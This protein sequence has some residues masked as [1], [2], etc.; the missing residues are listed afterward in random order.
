MKNDLHTL[1]QSLTYKFCLTNFRYVYFKLLLIS[2]VIVIHDH[3]IITHL[4]FVHKSHQTI[5]RYSYKLIYQI[6]Y[7]GEEKWRLVYYSYFQDVLLYC[8]SG[9]CNHCHT[10]MLYLC[11]LHSSLII[12]I[13]WI[14]LKRI[15]S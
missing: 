11:K 2:A 9:Y 4:H 5:H 10:T 13:L 1:K 7:W 8:K 3:N 6:P 12:C 15:K 14:Q